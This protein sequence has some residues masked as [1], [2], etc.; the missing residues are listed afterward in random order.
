MKLRF[1][2]LALFSILFTN[3]C[4]MLSNLIPMPSAS[5]FEVRKLEITKVTLEDVS[6]RMTTDVRN[7][8]PVSLPASLLN[9]NVNLEGTQLTKIKTDLGQIEASQVKSLPLD[10]T[11][12]YTDLMAIYKK[13][14]GKELLDMKMD[15]TLSLP[16][17]ASIAE[18]AGKKSLD[19]PFQK[20]K[21]LP[22][23]APSLEVKNFK[24]IQPK[25]TNEQ[26]LSAGI[27]LASRAMGEGGT[28][29]DAKADALF[30]IIVSNKA[31]A[32]MKFSDF[33][34]DLSLN[35]EKFVSGVPSEIINNGTES[36][37]KVKSSFPIGSASSGITSALKSKSSAFRITGLSGLSVPSLSGENMNFDFD[38]A[39]KL[40]W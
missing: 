35:G 14:P 1:L 30:D 39:G 11:M 24:I 31:A 4:A 10:F 16:L 23:I 20:E 13:V 33:K 5:N 22:A 25:L 2:F 19:F 6:I 8:Y 17:P 36:I 15:G 34:F 18:T 38:K 40:N 37:I 26:A 32:A 27:D 28:G 12:K 29:S 3:T 9:M 7:P 21:K